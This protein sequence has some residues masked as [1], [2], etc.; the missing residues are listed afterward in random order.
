MGLGFQSI[1]NNNVPTPIQS[2]YA[3]NVISNMVFGMYISPP[4][5]S[6]RF[7]TLTI[8]GYDPDHYVSPLH[9]VSLAR[10][11]LQEIYPDS[12]LS[13]YT[14]EEQTSK[15]HYSGYWD[16]NLDSVALNSQPLLSNPSGGVVDSGTTITYGPESAILELYARLEAIC[17]YLD[18][19]LSPARYITFS[20]SAASSDRYIYKWAAV[21]CSTP[22]TLSF[23][24]GGKDFDLTQDDLYQREDGDIAGAGAG[25]C[26]KLGPNYFADCIGTCRKS[27][28]HSS[29]IGDGDCDDG[30]YGV[31]L[32]CPRLGCDSNDCSPCGEEMCLMKLGVNNFGS[33]SWLLG[34]NFMRK[35]YVAHDIENMRMGFSYAAFPSEV[36][37]TLAPTP[38]PSASLDRDIVISSTMAPSP[39][40]SPPSNKLKASNVLFIGGSIALVLS[41]IIS[42]IMLRRCRPT[43]GRFTKL[44]DAEVEAVLSNDDFD[45]SVEID[46]QDQDHQEGP[47]VEMT[48][49]K[50]MKGGG[51]PVIFEI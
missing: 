7:G 45:T 38:D 43:E 42:Y 8:G 22:L 13:G 16:I 12:D 51:D 39:T 17:Y 50:G 29:W 1:S 15:T 14:A 23:K 46:F 6:T 2:L 36:S 35:V 9:W 4:S 26:D 20:C 24:I 10:R 25:G 28:E 32:N 19:D 49:T 31:F 48:T 34:D 18:S 37:L 27:S 33:N 40:P 11:S 3:Q 41:F 30:E 47:M 44:A 21:P 5:S